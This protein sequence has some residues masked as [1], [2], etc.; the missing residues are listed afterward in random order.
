[1]SRVVVSKG[2]VDFP[3]QRQRCIRKVIA[4]RAANII[5]LRASQ[6][7]DHFVRA[8][9]MVRV[10]SKE[11]GGTMAG[12]TP[13]FSSTGKRNFLKISLDGPPA[14]GQIVSYGD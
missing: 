14:E 6:T 11:Y 1:M 5:S 8:R 10:R 13:L 12:Y 3:H 4:E 7:A 9:K 2:R